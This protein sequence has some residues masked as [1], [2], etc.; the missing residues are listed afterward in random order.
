MKLQFVWVGKTR[1]SAIKELVNDYLGR[2]KKFARVEVVEVR[3]RDGDEARGRVEKEGAEILARA[4]EG[5]FLV[6]LDVAGEEMDSF[7][8]A[9]LLAAHQNR[10]T[11]ESRRS[12]RWSRATHSR[13]TT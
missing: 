11:R 4:A 12:V 3:D 2:V 13:S 1:S 6:A 8:F 7:A 9:D 10:G 5:S